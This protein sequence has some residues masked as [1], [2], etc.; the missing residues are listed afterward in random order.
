MVWCWYKPAIVLHAL[1]ARLLEGAL[2]VRPHCLCTI[3]HYPSLYACDTGPESLASSYRW[4]SWGPQ[5][6]GSY[7]EPL[8][9]RGMQRGQNPACLA[10]EPRQLGTA[11]CGLHPAELLKFNLSNA[12][13]YFFKKRVCPRFR[14][15]RVFILSSP[16]GFQKLQRARRGTSFLPLAAKASGLSMW[17]KQGQLSLLDNFTVSVLLRDHRWAITGQ[18]HKSRPAVTAWLV[19]FLTD[20]TDV[21]RLPQA[22]GP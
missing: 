4:G 3:S 9:W 15:I 10:P 20:R 13:N 21:I 11:L 7:P 6:M 8:T 22:S 12:N 18:V 2:A 1:M 17:E 16:D 14:S 5:R 19:H